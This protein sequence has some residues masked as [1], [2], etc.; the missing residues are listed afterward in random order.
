TIPGVYIQ[1]I[2]NLPPSIVSVPTAIPS[3][4][5]YT[6]TA[7]EYVQDGRLLKPTMIDSIMESQQYFGS[8]YAEP[9][10]SVSF[11]TD[12]SGNTTALAAVDNT[13]QSKFL[14]FYQ[15]QMFYNNGGGQCYLVCLRLL[16]KEKNDGIING[17]D[18]K[19]DL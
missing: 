18:L 5:C 1:E 16:E 12:S 10:L 17:Y 7:T 6:E 14:L 8:A 19:N 11:S 15:L 4:I 13:K 9:G 2:P 3:F